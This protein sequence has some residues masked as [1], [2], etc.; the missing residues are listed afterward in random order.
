V[1]L[2]TQHLSGTTNQ[3]AAPIEENKCN[4]KKSISILRSLKKPTL[5]NALR[6]LRTGATVIVSFLFSQAVFAADFT[7]TSPGFFYIINGSQPNPTLTLV[8]G[9]TYTFAINTDSI[10]PF[11]IISPGVQNNNISQG[12]ITYTVP[13]VASNYNYICSV[14]FFGARIITVDPTPPPLPTIRILSL[15]VSSNVVLRSTGTNGW[16]VNPEYSTN[17]TTTNWFALSVLS[18]SFLNGINETI[19]GRPPGSNVFLRIRSR[20]N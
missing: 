5:L 13:T 15:A 16:S 19:C 1:G 9:Q 10:H 12:I 20:P 4:M 8:R 14:H 6:L 18:N 17:L 3:L 11:E 2:K 7:V